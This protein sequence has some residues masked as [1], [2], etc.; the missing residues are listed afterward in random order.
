MHQQE[1]SKELVELYRRKNNMTVN[2][3][4]KEC[5]IARKT[6]DKIM[7]SEKCSVLSILRI[8][9]RM[10]INLNEIFPPCSVE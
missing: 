10:N 5:G 8:A 7:T 2:E 4:C 1:I 6:Y 9:L 3:F